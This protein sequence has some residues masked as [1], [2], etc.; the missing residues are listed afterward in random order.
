MILVR[1]GLSPLRPGRL[2]H[3]RVCRSDR[4]YC[5]FQ[6]QDSVRGGWHGWRELLHLTAFFSFNGFG[7]LRFL[8]CRY[9]GDL[10][11]VISIIFFIAFFGNYNRNINKFIFF[12]LLILECSVSVLP[13]SRRS[14]F[15]V[16]DTFF[17]CFCIKFDKYPY[18]FGLSI[19]FCFDFNKQKMGAVCWKNMAIVF[20]NGRYASWNVWS[21][22]A[23]AANLD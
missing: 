6:C 1:C 7:M 8:C 11:F 10:F 20:V 5:S 22:S 4:E 15:H 13:L 16:I 21:R 19:L 18:F 12:D 2:R 3:L 23:W 14:F 9:R 17:Q